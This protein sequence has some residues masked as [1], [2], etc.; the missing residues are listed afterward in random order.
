MQ[1]R[2]EGDLVDD[3]D[4]GK[5]YLATKVQQRV[6]DRGNDDADCKWM[7]EVALPV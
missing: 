2:T 5:S 7:Q 1:D 6:D 3:E 4:G